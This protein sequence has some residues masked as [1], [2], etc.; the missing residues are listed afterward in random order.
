MALKNSVKQKL[1]YG[2]KKDLTRAHTIYTRIALNGA[3]FNGDGY[4]NLMNHDRRDIAQYVFFEVAAQYESFC[5]E[6]FKIEVRHRFN[7]EPKRAIHLMGSSD[8]GLVGVMGWA[9]P[10]V[11]QSRAQCLHGKNGFFGRFEAIITK[12]TYDLLAHAH[13]VRN[14]I[15]HNGGKAVK[16]Y[17]NILQ[18]LAVPSRSRKGLHVGRL[19]MDYPDSS[20]N[21]SRWFDK[22]LKAYETVV[23]EFN[24]YVII[25]S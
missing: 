25:S 9:S 3:H 23:D 22:F 6:A 14:R 8:K 24:N 5:C 21:G 18:Q 1:V 15:A 11:I 13:K 16:D 4:R 20:P 19:L 2:F 12:P 17:N 10:S 7:V